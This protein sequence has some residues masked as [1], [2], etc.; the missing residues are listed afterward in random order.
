MEFDPLPDIYLLDPVYYEQETEVRNCLKEISEA[1]VSNGMQTESVQVLHEI[2]D[3]H[4]NMFRIPFHVHLLWKS[5]PWSYSWNRRLKQYAYIYE[6]TVK[7][8]RD[9]SR[10]SWQSSYAMEL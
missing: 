7:R 9:S 6:I 5:R 8:N 10:L 3:D 1:V 2:M 4:V